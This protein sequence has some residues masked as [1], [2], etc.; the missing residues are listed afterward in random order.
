[1][2]LNI[3]IRLFYLSSLLV[4]L[5]ACAIVSYGPDPVAPNPPP[6]KEGI[7]RFFYHTG[8]VANPNAEKTPLPIEFQILQEILEE[9]AGF[10][11]AIVSTPPQTKGIH[12]TV[13]ET[14]KESSRLS[15]G[16]CSLNIITLTVLPCYSDSGGYLVQYDLYVDNDLKKSYRFDITKTQ[17]SWIGLLPFSWMNAFTTDYK[18]AF[19]ATVYQFLRDSQKDGYL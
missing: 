19:K 12:L 18:E 9:K 6:K 7:V 13:Y 14:Q 17:A 10:A 15:Q 3:F 1:M 8:A 5:S 4:G 16:F 11:A 2:F